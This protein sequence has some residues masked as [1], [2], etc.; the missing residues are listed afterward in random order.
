MVQPCEGELT[1][2]WPSRRVASCPVV[3]RKDSPLLAKLPGPVLEQLA[4]LIRWSLPSRVGLDEST[5]EDDVRRLKLIPPT[6][7]ALCEGV[8]GERSALQ[9]AVAFA[10][11]I[12]P[13]KAS[14]LDET[15][16]V[17]RL[18][19]FMGVWSRFDCGVSFL[20]AVKERVEDQ[21]SLLDLLANLH[22]TPGVG[23]DRS[24]STLELAALHL[25]TWDDETIALALRR[26]VT[27]GAFVRFARRSLLSEPS[28]LVEKTFRDGRPQWREVRTELERWFPEESSETLDR[29]VQ[30]EQSLWKA[31]K[32]FVPQGQ[33]PEAVQ[34]AWESI[35]DK[36]ASGFAHYSFRSRLNYWWS[37]CIRRH[38]FDD[39][40]ISDDGVEVEARPETALTPELL[41]TYREGYRLLRYTFSTR[42]DRV[43]DG[44][45]ATAADESLRKA[46][47]DLW[48][49]RIER[50][51][52]GD[53]EWTRTV[54]EIRSRHPE[55]GDRVIDNLI[56]R[57]RR[58]FWAYKLARIDRLRN[59]EIR[60]A[61]PDPRI[62]HGGA[63]EFP[64]RNE[65]GIESIAT[66]SRAVLEDQPML[67][68]FG[69]QMAGHSS[70]R[71]AGEVASEL[72]WWISDG[73]AEAA[74]RESSA[75]PDI[76]A[77]EEGAPFRFAVSELR[78]TKPDAKRVA[79]CVSEQIARFVPER[80]VRDL[81][82]LAKVASRPKS[83]YW[84]VPVWYLVAIE[85]LD[86]DAVLTRL[87][88]EEG[89]REQ[90]RR[91]AMA[92][93]ELLSTGGKG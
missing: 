65:S 61:R 70:A 47:D 25:S 87:K 52:E 1:A 45:E 74:I 63:S 84:A 71:V 12:F 34:A 7:I 60:S 49:H 18:K 76:L 50:R 37:A 3:G 2:A 39:T 10:A 75:R 43:A 41:R 16:R 64:L 22:A 29:S 68:A 66:I 4:R 62:A 33:L 89:E 53:D 86:V 26:H 55:V 78:Q 8:R 31:L 20:A 35:H 42:P 72:S 57:L 17:D 14:M 36:L 83:R 58:R 73:D 30:L 38:S 51:I 80:R 19:R 56:T 81:S 54:A 46:L 28:R 77:S 90:V 93:E 91:Y 85:R 69:A 88:P 40:T 59:S 92:L 11:S 82:Q 79:H 67:W 27:E 21:D 24:D 15:E 48:Y 5:L 32:R 9:V 6:L 44:V 13:Q 23:D